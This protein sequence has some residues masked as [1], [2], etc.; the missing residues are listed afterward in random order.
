M[1]TLNLLTLSIFA[2]VLAVSFVSAATLTITNSNIPTG[3]AHDAGSFAVTF[4]VQNS[5]IADNTVSVSGSVTSGTGTV[6]S[7]TFSIDDGSV[8]TVTESRSVTVNFDAHQTGNVAG[9]ITV[10]DSGSGTPKTLPFSVPITSSSELSVSS[11]TI[12]TGSNTATITIKN[13]GNTLLSNIALTG[14]GSFGVTFNPTSITSLAAG[15]S[16]D[17]I[18][19]ASGSADLITGSTTITATSGSTTATGTVSLAG[20]YCE[21]PNTSNDLDVEIDINNRE[22]FGDDDKWYP[23]DVVEVEITVDNK[24]NHDIDD[25]EVE[26]GL[27]NPSTG[28]FIQ[29]DNENGFNLKDGKEDTVTFTID[30]DD[31][32]DD[33]EDGDFDLY[34]RATGKFDDNDSPN[35]GENICEDAFESVEIVVDEFVILNDLTFS[36]EVSCGSDV[37]ITGDAWNIGDSDEDEVE[38]LIRNTELGISERIEVGDISEFDKESFTTTVNI[39]SDAQEKTYIIDFLVFDE[40]N[41]LFEND[42]DDE[43]EYKESLIVS[44]SCS[45]SST[46]STI[47]AELVSG[48]NAGETLVIESTVTNTGSS[49]ETYTV[50]AV[51]HADWADSVDITPTSLV[52]SAGQSGVVKFTFEVKDDASGEKTFDILTSSGNSAAVSQPVVFSITEGGFNWFGAGSSDGEG[53]NWYLWIIGALNVLLV[54]IIIVVALRIARS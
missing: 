44:G 27:Y 49:L 39:P 35:D 28:E 41:D 1:K 50:S 25:I 6:A 4:D 2:M 30:L 34:V 43:S 17:V 45:S 22:G 53:S 9:T 23:F 37:Q 24:G 32:I 16:Q 7:S 47:S 5:G 13:E 48:G 38:V 18:V 11:E 51:N 12:A 36:D 40:D 54:V 10:D 21:F 20:E 8:N 42:D 14:S 46:Q 19:T 52:L 26:W 29:D 15:A 3:V 31:D 33:F